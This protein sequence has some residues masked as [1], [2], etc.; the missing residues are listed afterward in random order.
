MSTKKKKIVRPRNLALSEDEQRHVDAGRTVFA[1]R[2]SQL[3]GAWWQDFRKALFEIGKDVDNSK[4]LGPLGERGKSL[5]A[6]RKR[7]SVGLNFTLSDEDDAKENGGSNSSYSLGL[8]AVLRLA[9]KF[10]LSKSTPDSDAVE[11]LNY[12]IDGCMIALVFRGELQHAADLMRLVGCVRA[13][14]EDR[15][16]TNPT[17][18]RSGCS[19]R[20]SGDLEKLK[21]LL[22]LDGYLE[23]AKIPT[24]SL[25]RQDYSATMQPPEFSRLMR[26]MQIKAHLLDEG[27]EP[28]PENH[29]GS[30]F[31]GVVNSEA[32]EKWRYGNEWGVFLKNL[33]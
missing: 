26:D 33:V 2:L 29:K 27:K 23:Q 4:A 9:R 30:S 10:L 17:I 28:K 20:H 12:D 13:I 19:A 31:P 24:K 11:A 1:R 32:F 14:H 5:E 18:F 15:I 6:I 22:V 16:A 25:L 7:I 3:T 8:E 21:L